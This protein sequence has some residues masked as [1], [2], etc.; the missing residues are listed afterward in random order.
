MLKR[1]MG[2]I[3]ISLLLL[4]SA[5]TAWADTTVEVRISAGSDDAEEAVNDG[6]QDTYNT[7]S[8][9]EI[10]DDNVDNGG[11]QFIGMNFRGIDVPRRA[12]IKRAY[13][14]FVC[15]EIKDGTADAFLLIWV[16]SR[17]SSIQGNFH[18]RLLLKSLSSF[19]L[20]DC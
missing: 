1:F 10:T 11:R 5:G 15:D 6:S 13:I 9:L 14:E 16:L 20:W 17:N 7:S 19:Q 4:I 12:A 18:D 2:L 8:D 3:S